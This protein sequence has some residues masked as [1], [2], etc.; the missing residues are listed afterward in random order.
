MYAGLCT[1]Y[2]YYDGMIQVDETTGVK[3]VQESSFV[4]FRQTLK[5]LFWA[6]FCMSPVESADVVI[7]N[8]PGQND[9]ETVINKH[10]FTE[11][12]GHICFARE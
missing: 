6:I 12:V 7:E 4:S 1:L 5:T 10:D 9:G 8:L 2:E 3:T 11:A